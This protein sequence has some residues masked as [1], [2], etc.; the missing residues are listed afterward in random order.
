MVQLTSSRRGTRARRLLP[1]LAMVT[2]N[3]RS[4]S[5]AAARLGGTPPS[6]SDERLARSD[7][8]EL[9]AG[10]G[11]KLRDT[12]RVGAMAPDTDAPDSDPLI[13][14]EGGGHVAS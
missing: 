4:R 12:E 3:T 10:D 11:R 8:G 2:R 5:T 1:S 9:F 7:H 14:P 6:S 13:V